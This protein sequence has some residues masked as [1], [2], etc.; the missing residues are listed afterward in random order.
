[1]FHYHCKRC[2][3]IEAFKSGPVHVRDCVYFTP[4]IFLAPISHL[5]FWGDGDEVR[6]V[7]VEGKLAREERRGEWWWCY[8]RVTFEQYPLRWRE[9]KRRVF[10][11][12]DDAGKTTSQGRRWWW[13]YWF[14]TAK[15][16]VWCC[17]CWR[18]Q[19]GEAATWQAGGPWTTDEPEPKNLLGGPLCLVTFHTHTHTLPPF[20][21]H[22]YLLCPCS[23]LP[24]DLSFLP[25][26]ISVLTCTY[27][28]LPIYTLYSRL[29]LPAL[30]LPNI[31]FVSQFLSSSISL[32]HGSSVVGETIKALWL[33]STYIFPL[34]HIHIHIHNKV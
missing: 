1:M 34:S 29:P 10:V 30:L 9:H 14:L 31:L 12:D 13:C 28:Y 25:L 20:L 16:G 7:L 32:S 11:V 23:S 26:S 17:L 15:G 8:Q 22:S 2:H 5:T 18:L 4:P 6:C 3:V 33:I 24:P 21:H 27:H 19:A